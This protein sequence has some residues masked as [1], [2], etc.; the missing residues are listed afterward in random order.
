M[1]SAGVSIETV[2]VYGFVHTVSVLV[3]TLNYIITGATYSLKPFVLKFSVNVTKTKG[4]LFIIYF[5]CTRYYVLLVD[6][7]MYAR[8]CNIAP[9]DR[10]K[11]VYEYIGYTQTST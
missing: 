4:F 2:L 3:S 8:V 7:A 10:D 6:I 11:S 9:R 1:L 5:M